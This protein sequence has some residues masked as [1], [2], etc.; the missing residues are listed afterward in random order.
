[1]RKT[2][3]DPRKDVGM[4]CHQQHSGAVVEG[5]YWGRGSPGLLTVHPDL[6]LPTKPGPFSRKASVEKAGHFLQLSRGTRV[7]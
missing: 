7:R 4:T 3:K 2:W 6:R 5:V 1:M